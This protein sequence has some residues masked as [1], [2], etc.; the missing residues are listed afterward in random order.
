MGITV[1][2]YQR[3]DRFFYGPGRRQRVRA[4][5][6]QKTAAGLTVCAGF[7]L[8]RRYFISASASARNA[9]REP[10]RE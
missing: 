1:A 5:A 3:R 7:V 10:S 2:A 4:E 8:S 6:M 9:W